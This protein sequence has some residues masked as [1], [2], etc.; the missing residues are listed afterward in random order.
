VLLALLL[1]SCSSG[2]DP[3][4]TPSPTSPT[5]TSSAAASATAS[6]SPPSGQQQ[7]ALEAYR[8]FWTAVTEARA[9]PDAT[10]PALATYGSGA[11]LT[12][13][14]EFLVALQRE[15]VAY[16]GAPKLDP[17]VSDVEPGAAPAVTV[18]D[19][20][21]SSDWRPI[22]LSTGESAAAPGQET[23]FYTISR[24]EQLDG[25]WFVVQVDTDRSRTC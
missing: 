23:R 24:L 10:L 11:A 1:A 12:T 13:E 2:G 18:T 15:G 4:G 9:V 16:R 8:G 7:A 5:A 14:Q 19:C 17:E 20:I 6:P 25:Q 3:D 21:D 22:R